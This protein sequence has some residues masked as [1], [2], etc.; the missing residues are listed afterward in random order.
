MFADML[1]IL[2]SELVVD[3]VSNQEKQLYLM[4]ESVSDLLY[5]L[6][7]FYIQLRRPF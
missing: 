7:V 2:Y 5:E 4:S 6:N 1:Y 3:S